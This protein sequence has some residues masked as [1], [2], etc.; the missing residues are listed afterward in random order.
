[1]EAGPLDSLPTCT[2]RSDRIAGSKALI[3]ARVFALHNLGFDCTRYQLLSS[4]D[5]SASVRSD[6]DSGGT[7]YDQAFKSPLLSPFPIP[8]HHAVRPITDR[9]TCADS[10]RRPSLPDDPQKRL[11]F[12]HV[13]GVVE[14]RARRARR[15]RVTRRLHVPT[16]QINTARPFPIL[17]IHPVHLADFTL[18]HISFTLLT[19]HFVCSCTSK[20]P[21]FALPSYTI[22]IWLNIARFGTQTRSGSA[23]YYLQFFSIFPYILSTLSYTHLF[24]AIPMRTSPPTPLLTRITPGIDFEMAWAPILDAEPGSVCL[25]IRICVYPGVQCAEGVT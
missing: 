13:R 3:N 22:T 1:M 20:F 7:V 8:S 2:E 5:R 17:F 18:D 24:I 12:L 25:P 19:S 15:L 4:Q 11:S 21:C 6:G 23:L 10:A 14:V 9:P 16:K